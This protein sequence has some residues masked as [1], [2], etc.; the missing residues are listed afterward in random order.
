[1]LLASSVLLS[2]CSGRSCDR[3]GYYHDSGSTG[4]IVVPEGQT[5]PDTRAA[6]RIPPPASEAQVRA[7]GSPCLEEPPKYFE[8]SGAIVG[9][10]EALIYAWAD[11]FGQQDFDRLTALYSDYFNAPNGDMQA[12]RNDK[13]RQMQ[14]LGDAR[15]MI[16]GLSMAPAAGGRMVARFIQRIQL[17]NNLAETRKELVLV[18]DKNTW[19]IISESDLDSE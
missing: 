9:S 3:P 2:A 15:V 4:Q 6:L 14:Q 19:S 18:R 7:E 10:P 12:W 11:A 1:L 17:G 13:M 8:Q 16:E 5:P